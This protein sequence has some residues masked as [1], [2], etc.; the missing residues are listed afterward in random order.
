MS[1]PDRPSGPD[2]RLVGDRVVLR[3]PV[4]A[5]VEPLATIVVE[6]GIARWW[7]PEGI[8]AMRESLLQP[9]D[10]TQPWVIEHDGRVVGYI[11]SW[12]EPDPEFRHAGIDLFLTTSVQGQGLGPDAIRTLARHLFEDH[13]HHRLTIDPA[14]VNATAIA[15][16][17]KVGFRPVGTL[18]RYQRLA[19]GTWIDGL[20][21]ELLVEEL[22]P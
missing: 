10:D 15:A 22:R 6:P 9:E 2:Q 5:D 12:E 11:Q 20:L 19:D 3:A 18:R 21:M 13:G 17:T 8:D 14:A 16:Y 1:W 7:Q 4:E